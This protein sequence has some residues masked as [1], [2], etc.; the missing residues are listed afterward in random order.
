MSRSSSTALS[1]ARFRGAH[2]DGSVLYVSDP[3]PALGDLVEL[4]VRVGGDLCAKAVHVRSTVDG[5]Q[6]FTECVQ[7]GSSQWWAATTRMVNARMGYRFLIATGAGAL[8]VNASGL[9]EYEVTDADDFRLSVDPAP[10]RWAR[11]AVFYEIFPDRFAPSRGA[12]TVPAPGWAVPARWED[13]VAHGTAQGVRQLY[14]GD[15]GGIREHLDHLV[16]LGVTA[17]YLTPVF[18]ATSNHR[19]D[20]AT[21]EHVDPLLGGDRALAE[22]TD[23]A[24]ER[25]LRIIGDL[26][27]NHTGS[28]HEWFTAA[29]A[30]SQSVEAG[31]YLFSEHPDAYETFAGV[32]TMPKLD[33]RESQLRQ[34]LFEGPGSVVHRY[35]TRPGLDGWRIDVA[36]SAGHCGGSDRTLA[37]ART[38]VTTARAARADAYVVAE[39]QFDASDVLAGDGWHGTMAYAAFTRPV[40]SWLAE[41][42]IDRYWG[43]PAGHAPYTG[44][45]M[46][47][48]M[49]AWHARIPWRSRVHSLNLLDSHDTPRLH[50]IVGRQRY[51][52]AL[53]LLMTMPGIPMLFAGDEIG[54]QGV[55][56]EDAR[57]PFRW[58]PATWDQDLLT[59]HRRLI[60]L[61]RAHAALVD[62]GFRW[63]HT[64]DDVVVFERATR[65][66]TIL[67]HAARRAH[68]P[69]VCPAAAV[70]LLGDHHLHAGDSFP[71]SGAGIGVWQ[72]A[73][74][75]DPLGG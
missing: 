24:H 57:R 36:Q 72:L 47:H 42:D 1:A 34:R 37:T 19:Y 67:V 14:G 75:P 15:L 53:G 25:G 3:Y 60:G 2:H 70:D 5:D 12:P 73:T 26:T 56:P 13:P 35:L 31:F 18:P 4:R 51:I 66:Q 65:E 21:F 30:D 61:R 38:T 63:V 29:R 43:V 59:V 27:L 68:P 39:H 8:T 58:D 48:V 33:H 9:H 64:D 54:T 6:R 23:A 46:A 22:L 7:E 44:Q 55:D 41:Q 71:H 50:G 16:D 69:L 28:T 32:R 52:V 74:G 49:D 40:W 45:A 17:I 62:G 11:E 10:P 20:A